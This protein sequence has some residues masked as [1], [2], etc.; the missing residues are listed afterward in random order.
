M[1][2]NAILQ[3]ADSTIKVWNI[4]KRSRVKTAILVPEKSRFSDTIKNFFNSLVLWN[5]G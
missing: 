1:R 4:Q 2:L 3:S 5:S